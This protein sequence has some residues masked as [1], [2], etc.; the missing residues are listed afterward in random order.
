MRTLQEI[1]RKEGT[2]ILFITHD[3]GV[4]R[5]LCQRVVVM[6]KGRI[7]EEGPVDQVFYH[8]REEY[9]KRLIASRPA[10]RKLKGG[11]HHV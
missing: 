4:I 7:V 2:S 3:L 10:R 11:E 5:H 9:T 6:Q 8:P 1:N